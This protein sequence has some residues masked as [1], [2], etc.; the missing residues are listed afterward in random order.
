MGWRDTVATVKGWDGMTLGTDAA[1]R[2]ADAL[3]AMPAPDRIALARELLAGTGY[4]GALDDD[5]SDPS[6]PPLADV[7]Q[8]I[9]PQSSPFVEMVLRKAKRNGDAT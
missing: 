4:E 9:K 5:T 7:V 1:K 2:V 8:G 3:A 6:L